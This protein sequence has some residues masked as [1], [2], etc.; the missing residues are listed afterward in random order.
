SAPNSTARAAAGPSRDTLALLEGLLQTLAET[1]H[2]T[3]A[4]RAAVDAAR[5]GVG[6]DAAFWYSRSSK[7]TGTTGPLT[8]DQAAQFARKLI[9]AIPTDLEVFRWANPDPPAAGVP[10]AALVARTARSGGSV[11]VLTFTPGRRF[12]AADPYTAGHSE[13]VARIAVLLGNQLGLSAGTVGDLFLA[14][15]IHDIGKIGVR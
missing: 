14:G 5:E 4:I 13:R 8:P 11:V 2:P 10:T 12:D 6:A 3:E 7:A 1:T 15:L 9:H